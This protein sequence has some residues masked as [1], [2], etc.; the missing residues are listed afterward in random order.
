M[1]SILLVHGLLGSLSLINS[2]FMPK[3]PRMDGEKM[4]Y[5]EKI[6]IPKPSS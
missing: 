1:D 6:S 4:K 5:S 2:S 3:T